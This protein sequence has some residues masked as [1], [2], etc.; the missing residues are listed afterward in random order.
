MTRLPHV[1]MLLILGGLTAACDPVDEDADGWWDGQDN[2][3]VSLM[4]TGVSAGPLAPAVVVGDRIVFEGGLATSA[5]TPIQTRVLGAWANDPATG[6]VNFNTSIRVDNVPGVINWKNEDSEFQVTVGQRVISLRSRI[7]RFADPDPE[8]A[9]A[10]SDS[11]FISQAQESQLAEASGGRI[12]DP[13]ARDL[14]VVV[15]VTNQIHQMTR[16]AREAVTTVFRNRD[17]NLVFMDGTQ[18]ITG[19]T[20]GQFL[21]EGTKVPPMNFAPSRPE[22][23]SDRHNHIPDWADDFTHFLV[24][25][26]RARIGDDIYFGAARKPGFELISGSA[27]PVTGADGHD[28]QAKTIMHE[29]GHNLGLCHPVQ[30]TDSNCPVLPAQDMDPAVTVMGSP[31]AA[32]NPALWV[33][34]ALARPLDYTEAQ[35][36]AIVF[37]GQ[38]P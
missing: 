19:F 29:L 27:L 5:T 1:L 20:S 26:D 14:L 10:D 30:D 22:T 6:D 9:D 31:A 21:F 25:A 32:S 13:E 11:D 3:R 4:V 33:T 34:Q 24:M 12:G 7:E 23:E 15:A 28:F 17:I 37:N 18:S 38:F 35:W 2:Q 36:A 16:R 8:S